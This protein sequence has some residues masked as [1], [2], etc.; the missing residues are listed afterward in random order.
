[1]GDW[2][3]AQGID[4]EYFF[5]HSHVRPSSLR[6][7]PIHELTRSSQGVRTRDN[8]KR[9]QKNPLGSALSE[10]EL[11]AS[12]DALELL[13]AENGR[14]MHESGGR[15]ITRLPGAEKLINALRAGGARFGIVTSG[16]SVLQPQRASPDPF[17]ATLTYASSALAT[18][19]IMLPSGPSLPFLIT[20][21]DCHHGKPHPEPYLNGLAA[22]RSLPGSPI[23][24]ASHVLVFEDAPSGLASGL[25]A[26]CRTLA[27]CTGQ[28]RERIRGTEATHKVVDLER[29]EVVRCDGE[30]ITLRIRTLA[31]EEEEGRVD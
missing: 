5:S 27:V 26:G 11:I 2:C 3:I 15:G 29:V 17:A 20:A 22:L 18:A 31:E 7:S 30:S 4:P 25:A 21:G 28:T 13:I 14:I 1:M 19:E 9:F 8:I 16:A 24:D 23:P 6:R 12:V 10:E